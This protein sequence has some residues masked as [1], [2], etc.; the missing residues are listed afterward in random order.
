[1]PHRS[2]ASLRAVKRIFADVSGPFERLYWRGWIA[3][4]GVTSSSVG[5]EIPER[6]TAPMPCGSRTASRER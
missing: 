6:S 5:L 4:C 2:L 1:M 3:Y